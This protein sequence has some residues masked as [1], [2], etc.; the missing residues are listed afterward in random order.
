MYNNKLLICDK[1][2]KKK[3]KCTLAV[4]E[5]NN[6]YIHKILISFRRSIHFIQ[7]CLKK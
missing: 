6:G 1:K 3:K 2:K 4:Y 5:K 7:N